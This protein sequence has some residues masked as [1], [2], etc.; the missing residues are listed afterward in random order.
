MP[1]IEVAFKTRLRYFSQLNW[2]EY[3][4]EVERFGSP[5]DTI[6][7]GGVEEPNEGVME[8]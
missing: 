3:R 5:G 8:G 7:P 1:T 4:A 6:A 2:Q